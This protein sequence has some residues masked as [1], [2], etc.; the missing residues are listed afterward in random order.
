[1]QSSAWAE[2]SHPADAHDIAT[3][4]FWEQKIQAVVS[5]E[6]IAVRNLQITQSYFEIGK[7]FQNLTS[8]CGADGRCQA[9]WP[10][11]AVWASHTVGQ[12]IRKTVLE[13][14]A[15]EL[16]QQFHWPQWWEHLALPIAK[17]AELVATPLFA[18]VAPALGHGNR[19]VFDEVGSGFARFGV[20][21]A[22]LSRPDDARLE[23]FLAGFFANQSNLSTAMHMYYRAMWEPRNRT[24]LIFYANALVG[25]HEQVRLQPDLI[26][27]FLSNVT[28]DI[29]GHA[30][31]IL[32]DLAPLATTLIMRMVLPN[33]TLP[34]NQDVPHRPWDGQLWPLDLQTLD[35]PEARELYLSCVPSMT[36]M[37]GTA[38]TDWT[39]LSQR[40]RW[41]WPMFRSRQDSFLNDCPPY[42]DDS[43]QSIWSNVLPEE[44][45]ICI[46]YTL[47]CCKSTQGAAWKD[48][49]MLV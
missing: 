49:A 25:L 9:N 43:L 27:A 46:P 29:A 23:R 1:M 21:F 33:E 2:P 12:G 45:D 44:S 19:V 15:K 40:M 30:V 39:Y 6:D 5:N 8:A 38:A 14:F 18:I 28:V 7:L 17:F 32:P 16:A 31:R 24:Q 35:I 41:V 48:M 36:T 37:E 34:T 42:S 11:V 13:D 22:N 10:T 4:E 47:Q 26:K 20:H 3:W